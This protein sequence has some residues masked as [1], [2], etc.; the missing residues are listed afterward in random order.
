MAPG[1]PDDGVDQQIVI[2]APPDKP[3]LIVRLVRWGTNVYLVSIGLAVLAVFVLLLIDGA[4]W[5]IPLALF[6]GFVAYVQ[7]R[8]R[9]RR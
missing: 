2:E 6:F 8:N 5:A 4:L 1:K 7:L 3:N 9:R